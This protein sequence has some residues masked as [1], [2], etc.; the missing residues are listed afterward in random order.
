MPQSLEPIRAAGWSQR[1]EGVRIEGS[2]P[3]TVRLR[4]DRCEVKE[5]IVLR[6][7]PRL[8]NTGGAER[9]E[10]GPLNTT[11]VKLF[12]P[13]FLSITATAKS[14][15]ASSLKSPV[16]MKAARATTEN[17]LLLSGQH[18]AAPCRGRQE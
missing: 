2:K 4:P 8:R 10:D 5:A 16:A 15:M 1:D 17:L 11:S 9:A 7:R 3:K 6:L 13:A 12:M 14:S 18:A